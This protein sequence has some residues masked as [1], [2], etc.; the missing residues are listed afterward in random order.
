MR[1]GVAVG[2][3]QG[4]TIV[5]VAS[6]LEVLGIDTVS[7]GTRED[8][9]FCVGTKAVST[10]VGKGSSGGGTER[11]QAANKNSENRTGGN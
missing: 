2:D 8:I 4:V 9:G 6:L 10:N 5:G 7:A 11:S 3:D 1:P